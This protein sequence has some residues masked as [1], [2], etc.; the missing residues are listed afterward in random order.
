MRGAVGSSWVTPGSKRPPSSAKRP[1]RRSS[2]P[3]RESDVLRLVAKG[4]TNREIG[5]QLFISEKT[6]SVHVSNAM[7]K[8]GALSRYEA[9]AAAEKQGL[10]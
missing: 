8:L 5:D 6:V 9:A 10:L 1:H 4:H 7:A 2:S 3:A